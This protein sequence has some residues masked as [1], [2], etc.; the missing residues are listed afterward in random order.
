MRGCHGSALFDSRTRKYSY[1]LRRC[2]L[3]TQISLG[4][5][6][7]LLS[8]CL[9]ES[10]PLLNRDCLHM[11]IWHPAQ[12]WDFQERFFKSATSSADM[13]KTI[14]CEFRE[15][16]KIVLQRTLKGHLKPYSWPMAETNLPL[17][18]LTNV[19]L[20]SSYNFQHHPKATCS[21]ASQPG[22]L[23]MLKPNSQLM[24]FRP[25]LVS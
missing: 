22:S 8:L 2:C 5:H 25:Q 6:P 12:W 10:Q 23:S 20:M 19:C 13:N 9:P 24:F 11:C 14:S 17:S 16:Q 21:S 3:E 4:W 15:T 7:F 18:L 1:Y